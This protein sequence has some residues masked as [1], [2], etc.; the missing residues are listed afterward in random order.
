MVEPQKKLVDKM[1]GILYRPEAEILL[2]E[3]KVREV[4]VKLCGALGQQR[5]EKLIGFYTRRKR[6]IDNLVQNYVSSHP[7]LMVKLLFGGTSSA[8]QLLYDQ[9]ISAEE[10]LKKANYKVKDLH[11]LV[12]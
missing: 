8:Q 3:N 10:K 1:V 5:A 11:Y 9:L 12:A 7:G 2:P 4:A 6:D